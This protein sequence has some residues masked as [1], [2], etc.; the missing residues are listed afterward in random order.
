[1]DNPDSDLL[2]LLNQRYGFAFQ[3]HRAGFYRFS[4][5]YAGRIIMEM[6]FE[7]PFDKP[8]DRAKVSKMLGLSMAQLDVAARNHSEFA[9]RCLHFVLII[10]QSHRS[11]EHHPRQFQIFLQAI[12]EAMLK[13]F[14]ETHPEE[15]SLLEGVKLKCNELASNPEWSHIGRRAL[16]IATRGR[17]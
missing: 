11:L 15:C 7:V 16:V 14:E 5:R 10:T 13:D 3:R 9:V 1:M 8:A 12:A 6:P 17:I 4:W 2:A